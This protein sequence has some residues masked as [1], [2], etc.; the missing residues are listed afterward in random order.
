MKKRTDYTIRPNQQTH[1]L[2][3]DL[4]DVM[5]ANRVR[6]TTAV[7][8]ER[9]QFLADQLNEDCWYFNRG[10]TRAEMHGTRK[11]LDRKE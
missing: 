4:W 3:A 5:L 9:A 10:Q 11:S 2:Q 1:R 7:G 6:I 8:E